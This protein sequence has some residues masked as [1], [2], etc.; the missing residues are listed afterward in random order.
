[1]TRKIS[2]V[3]NYKQNGSKA[4]S[5]GSKPFSASSKP[6]LASGKAISRGSKKKGN[7]FNMLNF[8]RVR[9]FRG[10]V[11]SILKKAG[12]NIY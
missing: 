10:V 6:F 12:K 9:R 11:R 3:W 2:C 1:M 4:I 8:G 7:K 5:R